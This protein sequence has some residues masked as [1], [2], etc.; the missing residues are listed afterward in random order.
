M[1]GSNRLAGMKRVAIHD[2]F[3]LSG[4]PKPEQ[5]R[6]L[7]FLQPVTLPQGSVIYESSEGME[8]VYF[9]TSCVVSLLYTTENGSTVEM[10]SVGNEGVV[11]VALFLGGDT[12]PNR[13]VV[14]VAG[15]A[16]RMKAKKLRDEFSRGGPFQQ[17]LLRY[18][19]ALITQIS[20]TAVCNRLHSVQQRLCR[21]LLSSHDRA[22]S[23]QLAMTHEFIANMLGSRRESV[24]VAAGRLQQVG[25][26]G[27]SRGHIRILGRPGLE[28]YTCECY[29]IVKTETD[30][31][32]QRASRAAT[33]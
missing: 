19:Q 7:P 27:Y 28:T 25:L 31:L 33:N 15:D 5:D 1:L 23:D 14:Q 18:T 10:G 16:F 11:G 6:L 21:L 4:L 13:A 32:L 30:R 29:R 3:L 20:Q 26:I 22:N 8:Y 9:P 12:T 24:A 2:Q 17:L